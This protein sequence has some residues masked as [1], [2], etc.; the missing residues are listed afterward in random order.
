MDQ[1]IPDKVECLKD[2]GEEFLA[3]LEVLL[4]SGQG[5]HFPISSPQVIGYNKVKSGKK[6]RP[7]DMALIEVPGCPEIL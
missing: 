4:F 7:A 2:C 3:S 6:D 1:L 5:I